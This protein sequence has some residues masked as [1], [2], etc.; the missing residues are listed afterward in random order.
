M[1]RRDAELQSNKTTAFAERTFNPGSI[2]AREVTAVRAEV[3]EAT[4]AEEKRDVKVQI[5]MYSV[6]FSK[7]RAES[8]KPPSPQ[9]S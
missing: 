3:K 8:P 9:S 5:G 2:S 4:K 7:K 6:N 1:A